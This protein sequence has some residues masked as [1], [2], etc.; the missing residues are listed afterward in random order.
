M[1]AAAA[2][3]GQMAVD[4]AMEV[5]SER[6]KTLSEALH[7]P[8]PELEKLLKDHVFAWNNNANWIG[9]KLKYS[10]IPFVDLSS[11]CCLGVLRMC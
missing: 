5:V 10:R 11:M 6:R 4:P 9:C 7:L 8:L 3:T 2:V 1:S